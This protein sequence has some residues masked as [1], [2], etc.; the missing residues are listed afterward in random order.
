MRPSVL[1]FLAVSICL[2]GWVKPAGAEELSWSKDRL[3]IAGRALVGFHDNDTPRI[4]GIPDPGIV[5]ETSDS[6]IVGGQV[7]IGYTLSESLPIRLEAD[8]TYRFRHDVDTRAFSPEQLYNA[9]VESHTGSISA[10]YDITLHEFETASPLKLSLG[11]GIGFARHTIDGLFI[12]P[13][14][15]ISEENST[16]ETSVIWHLSAGLNFPLYKGLSGDIIY[17]YSDLGEIETASFTSGAVLEADDFIS[18]DIL[19]GLR[20]NF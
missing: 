1:T 16:D 15:G 9:D 13:T 14:A 8:Y 10:Y 11:G 3:Y 17:R 4:T 7:A 5:D 12:F 18:H 20:Y 6:V 19:I 2:V